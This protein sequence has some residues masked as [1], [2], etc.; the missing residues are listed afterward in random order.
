[1]LWRLRRRRFEGWGGVEA[2]WYGAAWHSM[3]RQPNRGFLRQEPGAGVDVDVDVDVDVG[4]EW[5]R[6]RLDT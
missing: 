3:A 5:L 2:V 4:V 6:P 1:M